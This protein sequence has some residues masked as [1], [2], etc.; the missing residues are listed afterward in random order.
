MSKETT[1]TLERIAQRRSVWRRVHEF[2]NLSRKKREGEEAP[3]GLQMRKLRDVDDYARSH[4]SSI[5]DDLKAAKKALK[6]ELHPS[7]I[8]IYRAMRQISMALKN[9][10]ARAS[11][12]KKRRDEDMK[13]AQTRTNMTDAELQFMYDQMKNEMKAANHALRN[14]L[15][16][17]SKGDAAKTLEKIHGNAVS[18]RYEAVHDL[19]NDKADRLVGQ[20][21]KAFKLMD[22]ARAQGEV[23]KFIDALELI[24]D[25][26]STFDASLKEVAKDH[27]F[28]LIGARLGI[29][30]GADEDAEE[31]AAEEDK[32]K[33]DPKEDGEPKEE[34]EPKDDKPIEG[35]EVLQKDEAFEAEIEG[36]KPRMPVVA[37]KDKPPAEPVPEGPPGEAYLGEG[38]PEYFQ[39]EDITDV[40]FNRS[41]GKFMKPVAP[42]SQVGPSYPAVPPSWQEFPEPGWETWEPAQAYAK[43]LGMVKEAYQAGDYNTAGNTMI[44]YSNVLMRDGLKKEAY[45]A[46]IT[47]LELLDE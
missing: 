29:E 43:L 8:D 40:R 18:S 6:N 47:A 14:H 15:L 5:K 27:I 30:E 10:A 31:P 28:P 19:V 3:Y 45:E 23:G 2:G 20:A 34:G 42:V 24:G 17:M 33:D 35:E 36:E 25:E 37:P 22:K 13:P 9:V 11:V 32:T 26:Q 44:T 21:L 4:A 39:P 1:A 16:K 7:Y 38:V 12:L 46:R 41:R